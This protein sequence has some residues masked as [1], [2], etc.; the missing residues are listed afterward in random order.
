MAK[1]SR[2]YITPQKTNQKIFQKK[3][4]SISSI[5]TYHLLIHP[6]P[7][8]DKVAPEDLE[9]HGGPAEA[10][11]A[12]VP[13]ASEHFGELGLFCG[14]PLVACCEMPGEGEEEGEKEG[15]EGRGR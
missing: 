13:V 15:E 9:V 11:E 1:S 12:E 4:V 5:F 10:G 2:Y 6:A 14:E 3:C 7:L 8:L